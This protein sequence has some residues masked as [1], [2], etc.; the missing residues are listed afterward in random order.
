MPHSFVPLLVSFHRPTNLR[1]LLLTSRTRILSWPA[2]GKS[3]TCEAMTEQS[4]RISDN[5]TMQT[6]LEAME[7]AE[8]LSLLFS[9]SAELGIGAEELGRIVEKCSAL[10]Q[11]AREHVQIPD[12]FNRHLADRGWIAYGTLDLDLAKEAI[13]LADAG[14]LDAAEQILADHYNETA[15][16]FIIKRCNLSDAFRPRWELAQIAKAEYLER[17]FYCAI[18]LTL[19]LIDGFVNEIQRT[20]FFTPRT[21]LTARDS[22]TGHSSGLK[23]L[24]ALFGR[25]RTKTTTEPLTIPYRHGILHGWDLGYANQMVAAKAWACLAAIADW[26]SDLRTGNKQPQPQAAPPS[27]E[28]ILTQFREIEQCNKNTA[29]WR[30]RAIVVGNTIPESGDPN[31]YADGSP[32]H[33]LASFFHYWKAKN[34]GK[35]ALLLCDI[36]GHVSIKSAGEIREDFGPV[37]CTG[38][39]FLEVRDETQAVTVIRVAVKCTKHGKQREMQIDLRLF[40]KDENGDSRSHPFEQGSWAI[41]K[42]GINELVFARW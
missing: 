5:P 34:Y 27:W 3:I 12:R 17:R 9:L 16:N 13:S 8:V 30:P 1:Q 37:E 39:R 31:G 40:Y 32:E 35:M 14:K 6:L 15:L 26:A 20:G 23:K 25:D 11:K 18:P 2:S 33:A 24:S 28:E 4:L 10:S 7:S 29:R 21:D 36:G 41:W 42:V 22:I 19:M 38:F